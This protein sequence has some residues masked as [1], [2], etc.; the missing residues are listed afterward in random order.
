MQE[1][2]K[3]S[4]GVGLAAPQ[5]GINRQ[6]VLVDIGQGPVMLINPKIMKKSG[7]EVMEEGCLSLP[8]IYV[9]VKR[10]KSIVV[11]A[12]NLD[13]EKTV[14]KASGLLARVMQH[15]IDHL[16]GKMIIDYAGV[17]TKMKLKKRLKKLI[18]D[19]GK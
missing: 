18:G 1:L 4:G 9:S 10:A 15:E 7:T 17:I 19:R 11:N 13:N 3:L 16:R 5:V 2:M 12:L 14:I 8:G 6:M